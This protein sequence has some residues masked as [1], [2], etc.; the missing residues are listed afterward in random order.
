VLRPFF[1]LSL[2]RKP[3]LRFLTRCE[4]SYVSLFAPR[5]ESRERP[6]CDGSWK[7]DV[8]M[9][10]AIA[11]VAGDGET[12]GREGIRERILRNLLTA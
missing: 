10:A 5:T 12:V 9:S 2:E 7:E 1:D 4:G 3:C 8:G 6:G 11:C